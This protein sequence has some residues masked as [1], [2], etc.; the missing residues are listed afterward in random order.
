[1]HDSAVASRKTLR[2]REREHE[3]LDPPLVAREEPAV[4]PLCEPGLENVGALFGPGLDDEVDM[5]LEL[6]R[7]DRRLDA[8]TV[9]AGFLERSRDGRLADAEQP[10]H[11]PSGRT[12]PLQQLT[13]RLALERVRPQPSQLARRPRQD[14]D[15][16]AR[17][18]LQDK[19]GSGSRETERGRR[20]WTRRLLCDAGSKVGIRPAE[21]FRDRAR[22]RLDLPL[23][24]LVDD[25][26]EPRRT[27]DELHRTVVVGR[28][29][30]A[31][32]EAGVRLQTLAQHGLELGGCIPYDRD[33]GR[34]E[35]VAE[36]LGGEEG[37]VSVGALAADELAAGDD[38]DRARPRVGHPLRWV[39]CCGVTRTW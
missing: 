9:A 12:R 4:E 26:L 27:R 5:D 1:M 23:E 34:L 13:H 2:R 38:D 24:R 14:D 20:D 18:R 3:L 33:P 32:D 7:A 21:A 10:Q 15:H 29:E 25:E 36:G 35:P 28:A 17:G 37:T 8:V 19:T 11:A 39:V 16:A 30:A 22:D 31:R 6:A